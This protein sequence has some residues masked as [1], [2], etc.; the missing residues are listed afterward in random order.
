MSLSVEE[1]AMI[2]SRYEVWRD[3]QRVQQW[4][5]HEKGRKLNLSNLTIKKWHKRLMETG[6]VC[7]ASR[8]RVSPS[9]SEEN[10]AVVNAMFLKSPDKSIRQAVCE[11]GSTYHTVRTILTDELDFRPWKPHY[12]QALYVE[13]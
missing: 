11:S 13:D 5:Y 10:V 6:S 2:A 8:R 7:D 9:R 1:R 12:D 3:V 4:W